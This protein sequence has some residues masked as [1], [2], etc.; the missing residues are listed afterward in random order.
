MKSILLAF[1]FMTIA[2]FSFAQ[3]K[4]DLKGPAA[5]NY[6]P[7]QKSDNASP[8]KVYTLHTSN[9][10]QGPSAKNSKVWKEEK[11][12]FQQVELV[13]SKPRTTGP[14]AKNAKPWNN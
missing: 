12:N 3:D 10:L 4:N 11:Q 9:K 14:K 5:K 7:W 8:K 2:T 6:K 13:S 1:A